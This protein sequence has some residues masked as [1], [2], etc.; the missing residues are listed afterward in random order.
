MV[1]GGVNEI[2]DGV[3]SDKPQKRFLVVVDQQG[4]IIKSK[5]L[6]PETCCAEAKD[7]TSPHSAPDF[8]RCVGTWKTKFQRKYP[9]ASILEGTGESVDHFLNAYPEP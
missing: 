2:G 3:M 8:Y 4:K 1:D 6:T 9:G 7:A 5:V